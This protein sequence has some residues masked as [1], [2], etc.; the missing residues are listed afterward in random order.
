MEKKI[1]KKTIILLAI[2]AAALAIG[3]AAFFFVLKNKQSAANV[4]SLS[5]D[6]AF[7]ITNL[8][9]IVQG[10]REAMKNKAASVSV[11]VSLKNDYM[12]DIS[13]VVKEIMELAFDHTGVPDEGDYLKYQIGGYTFNYKQENTGN[14]YRYT[15]EIIP[16]YYTT[17]G[18]EEAVAAE[19]E[20]I[21]QSLGLSEDASDYDKVLAVYD[22][23]SENVGYDFIHKKN[24]GY[25]MKSTAYNALVRHSACCQGFSV[26]MYRL[27][28]TLGVDNRI[29]IGQGISE[30][31]TETHSWNIVRVDGVYYN[32]DP[33][34][35]RVLTGEDY[36]LKNDEEF[37][38]HIRNEEFLTEE[39]SE[40]YPT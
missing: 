3:A 20:N 8:D 40:R 34:W 21:I 9:E 6:S 33:T 17:P 5:E 2:C 7:E 22:Y 28:L 39:F 4:Y 27:L 24:V 13:P 15:I 16:D 23:I 35:N 31:G 18:D 30:D 32:V 19:I 26:A 36:F 29:I 1:S 11:I 37:K 14:A 38:N 25:H 12:D 10:V